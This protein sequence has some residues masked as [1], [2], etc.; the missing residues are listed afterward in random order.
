MRGLLF[1]IIIFGCNRSVNYSEIEYPSGGYNYPNQAIEKE[2]GFYCYPI[3]DSM[4]VIDSFSKG[5]FGRFTAPSFK[6]PNMSLKPMGEDIFRFCIRNAFGSI[7][8]IVLKQNEIIVKTNGENYPYSNS[9]PDQ[10]TLK[11][12]D[13]ERIHYN[14]LGRWFPIQEK[15][16]GRSLYKQRYLDSITKLYPELLSTTYYEQLIDKTLIERKEK[17]T[18]TEKKTSITKKE[19]TEWVILLNKSGYWQLPIKTECDVAI[20]DGQFYEL[21]ASTKEKYNYVSWISCPGDTSN[22]YKACDALIKLAKVEKASS[23]IW[24]E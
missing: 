1:A 6:E 20:A 19:F 2:R 10:D 12:N 11:L 7:I 9:F 13:L 5:Y 3:K 22:F 15:R 23:P 17:F 8:F 21:E 18:Y 4:S 24:K 16:K 14:I